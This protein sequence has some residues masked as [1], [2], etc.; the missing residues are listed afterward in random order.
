M[1]AISHQGVISAERRQHNK[2]LRSLLFIVLFLLV[3]CGLWLKLLQ[4]RVLP[5]QHVRVEGDFLH[6]QPERLKT[7]SANSVRGGF[8][9]VDVSVIREQLLAEPWVHSIIVRRRWPDTLVFYVNE[10][11]PVTVWNGNGLI[12]WQGDVFV[13]Q[14][15]SVPDDLPMLSGPEGTHTELLSL[16][17]LLNRGLSAYD[18]S[19]TGLTLDA[20]RS[21]SFSLSDNTRV[22]LGNKEIDVRVN[23]FLRYVVPQ[24]V[25]ALQRGG[26]IDMR[27]T[28][29]F[30]V[31]TDSNETANRGQ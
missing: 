22:R 15:G 6:L 19:V 27:Y 20:R 3:V 24:L 26:V 9:S 31:N 11:V 8:F 5:I 29:G 16:F 28:N 14:T 30:S 13:P 18:L 12:N 7:L 23:R 4:P 1:T 2:Y 17:E 25:S 10:Q 21:I